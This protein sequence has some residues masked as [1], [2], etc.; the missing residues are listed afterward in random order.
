VHPSTAAT[1]LVALGATLE[2]ARAD[3]VERR[4]LLE[5][6]FVLPERDPHRENAL[7]L[8]LF[9]TLVRRTVL[10]AMAPARASVGSTP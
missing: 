1:V 8:P 7:R 9:E 4:V 5:D 6:F 3:G 10:A 2:L